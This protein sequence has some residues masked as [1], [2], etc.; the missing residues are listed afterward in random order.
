MKSFNRVTCLIFSLILIFSLC[1]CDDYFGDN[2]EAISNEREYFD[3]LTNEIFLETVTSDALTLHYTISYPE[4][5]GITNYPLTI[6]SYSE[7]TFEESYSDL[8]EWLTSLKAIEFKYLSTDQQLTYKILYRYC[9]AELATSDLYLYYEPLSSVYGDQ[10]NLPIL[11]AEYSFNTKKDID[12]YLALLGTVDD[13]FQEIIDFETRKSQNGLFMADFSADI[14]I[15]Q[16]KDFIATPNDNYL[17]ELFDEK[18]NVFPNLTDEEKA[19]YKEANKSLVLSDVVSAYETLI[20]GLTSLKGTG[21]NQGGV[22]NFE[23]GKDYFEYVVK[24]EIGSE[25]TVAE[26]KAMINQKMD[27][28]LDELS[29]LSNNNPNIF[30]EIELTS[31]STEDY[32]GTL[33]L[34]SR[35]MLIDFPTG[36]EIN[37][38][39]KKV[40]PTM[41]DSLSPAF[42][43]IPTIDKYDSNIIY[44]NG[45]TDI[46]TLAHEGYPGHMYQSTYFASTKPDNIRFLFDV[47]GYSEGWATYVEFYSYHI[48]G[49]DEYLASAMEA[50][51]S[52]TLGIYSLV[53]IGVNYEGWTRQDTSNYLNGL[54]INNPDDQKEI[55]E[56]M[57]GSPGNYLNYYVGYLEILE[58]KEFAQD[59]LGSAFV[60]KD[61][62][63]FLLETGPAPF[64]ILS[65]E[66]KISMKNE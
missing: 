9:S 61:F 21:T 13:Y 6:G 1:S 46:Q 42:Y 45:E 66:L 2:A 19:N 53:D 25:K 60:L 8:E 38:A 29:S 17:I 56:I 15:K 51:M 58:L 37:Y 32:Q 26:I 16:C 28:D 40:H 23:K 7:E 47:T 35:N 39:V 24:T 10:L 33:E 27:R 50:N 44:V 64:E 59:E 43:L 54:G 36:P 34:L 22:C 4:N 55:F 12:D 41:E 62:N 3:E 48:S 18:I 52:Y 11:F 30:D 49:L 20:D 65:E 14:I 5:Y 63:T 57:I 31:L